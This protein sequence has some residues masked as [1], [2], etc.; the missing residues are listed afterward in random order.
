MKT[1]MLHGLPLAAACAGLLFASAAHSQAAPGDPFAKVPPFPTVCYT[2]GDPFAARLDAAMD[3]VAKE[4]EKQSAINAKIEEDFRNI[5][6]M[7][8][9]SRMQQW[10]MDNPEEAMKYAQATQALGREVNT[11][12]PELNAASARFEVEDDELLAKY[13]ATLTQAYGPVKARMA[14]LDKRVEA[15]NGCGMFVGECAAPDW[16]YAEYDG[17]VKEMD[18]AYRATCAQWWSAVGP[19]HGYLKRYRDWLTQKWIPTWIQ[20]EQV[21][22]TQ[23]AIMNTP[24]ASYRPTIAYQSAHKYMGVASAMFVWRETRPN[25]PA[26]G[27]KD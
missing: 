23:Y 24:A 25:C 21:R 22:L 8:M 7:E 1:T 14:D 15:V 18:A 6:P 13:K 10:M 9:A 26:R 12:A 16:A 19:I 3:A 27:C 20:N 5:D 17:L 2:E 4:Q 11:V